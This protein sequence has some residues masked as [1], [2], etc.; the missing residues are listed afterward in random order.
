[1]HFGPLPH[2]SQETLLIFFK[3]F[4]KKK[5][6]NNYFEVFSSLLESVVSYL[7]I[8]EISA[9]THIE[10]TDDFITRKLLVCLQV[11]LLPNHFGV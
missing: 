2:M 7:V 9:E 3:W 4:E 8:L 6:M 5:A 10:D 1:M 11:T